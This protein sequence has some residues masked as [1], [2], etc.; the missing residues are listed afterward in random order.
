MAY[1]ISPKQSQPAR[2]LER[3]FAADSKDS[4]EM[5]EEAFNKEMLRWVEG[6]KVE[7]WGI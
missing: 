1:P 4:K 3:A 5:T 6:Q 7:G 2:P